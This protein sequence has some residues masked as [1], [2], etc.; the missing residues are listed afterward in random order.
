MRHSGLA[1]LLPSLPETVWVELSAGSVVMTPS[2][3]KDFVGWQLCTGGD[4]TLG[5]VDFS[6]FPQ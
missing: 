1:D 4:E 3:G 2:I 6:I 5:I